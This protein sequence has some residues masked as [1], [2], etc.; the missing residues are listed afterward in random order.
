MGLALQFDQY[1]SPDQGLLYLLRPDYRHTLANMVSISRVARMEL[2]LRTYRKNQEQKILEMSNPS[3][4][5]LLKERICSREQILFFKS[6]P[7]N[8]EEKI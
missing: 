3:W 7:Y 4:E 1:T 6:S 2:F 8:K 5:L